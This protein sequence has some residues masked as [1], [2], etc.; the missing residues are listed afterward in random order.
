MFVIAN[1]APRSCVTVAVG[2]AC[3]DFGN[4]VVLEMAHQTYLP[5]QIWS[6]SGTREVKS[7]L[8]ILNKSI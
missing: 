1:P 8:P 3:L 7:R 2:I 5:Y 4:L 6:Q